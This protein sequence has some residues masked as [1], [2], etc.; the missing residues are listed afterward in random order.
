MRPWGR[1]GGRTFAMFGLLAVAAGACSREDSAASGEAASEGPVPASRVVIQGSFRS[2]AAGAGQHLMVVT[3]APGDIR[4]R[5]FRMERAEGG[6]PG[7]SAGPGGGG[8]PGE[9]AWRQVGA[10]VPV[11]VGRSGVGPKQEGD[12]RSP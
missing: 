3:E 12:G 10:P 8:E 11:V 7:E 5:L 6:D 4:G 1:K 2:L 9:G